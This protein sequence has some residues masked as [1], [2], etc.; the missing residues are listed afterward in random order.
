MAQQI[1]LAPNSTIEC[2]S[3]KTKANIDIAQTG[4]E[5]I[6]YILCFRPPPIAGQESNLMYRAYCNS[7]CLTKDIQ[8][9]G[10]QY[11]CYVCA[12]PVGNEGYNYS[13]KCPL[14]AQVIYNCCSI[15]CRV[16]SMQRNTELNKGINI[17]CN[18][19]GRGGQFE[20]KCPRCMVAT[21]CSDECMAVDEK[22]NE[23]CHF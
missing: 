21:Y 19:C 9:R 18:M 15:P 7:E 10:A 20:K 6:R 23:V 4:Q 17:I 13:V 5:E 14:N 12:T 22:H 16:R 1:K 3:C 11:C 2:W 8:E